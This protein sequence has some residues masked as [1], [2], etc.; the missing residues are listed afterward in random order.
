MSFDISIILLKGNNNY[1]Y[2]DTTTRSC[3]IK[4]GLGA[5]CGCPTLPNY[6]SNSQCNTSLN[7]ACYVASA[8]SVGLGTVYTLTP[9]N[10]AEYSTSP[11]V[12]TSSF[13]RCDCKDGK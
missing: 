11:T 5:I 7:L 12:T 4:G 1:Y 3:L 6:I 9:C 2:Y 8:C 10:C 13:N